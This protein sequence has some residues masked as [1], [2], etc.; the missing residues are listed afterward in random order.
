MAYL[1]TFKRADVDQWISKELRD[2]LYEFAKDNDTK[3]ELDK[4]LN[5]GQI[6][7]Y[8]LPSHYC[9]KNNPR[10]EAER[11]ISM[12]YLLIN[13]RDTYDYIKENHVGVFHGT[14]SNA[15]PGIS[16]Y[17]LLSV[18]AIKERN[19]SV[20]SGE[21]WS[22]INGKRSFISVTDV[23]EV[24]WN[25][26]Q[27]DN[28]GFPVIVGTSDEKIAENNIYP[29]AVHS[30]VPEIGIKNRIPPEA[31]KCLFVP[32]DKV[33]YVKVLFNNTDIKVLGLSNIEKRYF[34]FDD[35]SGWQFIPEKYEE[36]KEKRFK[37][38]EIPFK[39]TLSDLK[40]NAFS[41]L[42]NKMQKMYNWIV[43]VKERENIKDDSKRL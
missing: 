31:I 3:N 34:W 13:D 2:S 32:R 25:Y 16:K 5:T 4:I 11:R 38:K 10:I 12:A 24:A 33:E 29:F 19:E 39:I 36:Y 42:K 7:N 8:Y 15:L 26:M 23:L 40:M 35:F 28:G 37:K 17:G 27:I 22:R 41:R 43:N 6:G 18:D 14:N 30:D 21:T 1:D 20:N 9:R